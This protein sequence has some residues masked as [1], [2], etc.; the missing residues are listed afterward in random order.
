MSP[1]RWILR[2]PTHRDWEED[3]RR[4]HLAMPNT[5]NETTAAVIGVFLT[6]QALSRP[7]V[8]KKLN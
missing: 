1:V 5:I 3:V 8:E 7:R 4:S 6:N 2:C